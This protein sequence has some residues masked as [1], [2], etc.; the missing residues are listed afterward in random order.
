M[1]LEKYVDKNIKR[2]KII[3]ITISA[4]VL[5]GF[6]FLLYKTFASFTESVEFPMMNGKVDYFGNSDIY[7]VFY[8]GDKQLEE[9]PQKDN[10]ENLVFD[11][12]TCDNGATI[13]W[14]SEEWGPIVKN[15][16]KSKTKCSLYFDEPKP[17]AAEYIKNLAKTD[18]T[19]LAY[20]GIEL[21]GEDIGTND[22]NLRYIGKNPN[23]YIDIGDKD[24]N[25]NPILWRIIGIMN[26]IENYNGNKD[27][28]LKVIR[29]DSIGKYTWD[30]SVNNVND[31]EGVN[32][33]SQAD[34]MKLLNPDFEK[35]QDIDSS[36]ATQTINNSLYWNS[37]KGKCYFYNNNEVSNE[38]VDCDFRS[39]G[40]SNIVKERLEKVYWNTGT[41]ET[42]DDSYI[43]LNTYNA[44]RSSHNGR[45]QCNFLEPYCNDKIDRTT[46]WLGYIGLMYP[47][48]Y[49][50]AVG[51]EAR[52][53]C[54]Q[55][56]LGYFGDFEC[57]NNDWLYNEEYQWTMTP[58]PHS[59]YAQQ[60]YAIFDEGNGLNIGSI[61]SYDIRPVVYLKSSVRI[62]TNPNPEQEYGSIGNPFI[63]E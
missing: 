36:G 40:I 39:S 8:E 45:E 7:F 56:P 21:L 37:E 28:Y 58:A 15:L 41:F 5:V 46:K 4:I 30:T 34:V 29:S 52:N 63:L 38:F 11:H 61:L 27:S 12:G 3:L 42:E 51:E 16:S 23:N 54:L 57:Q 60:V 1:K 25:G 2:R 14:D 18:T 13:E 26:N 53:D 62:A 33:W 47:S 43:Y 22:N 48:D 50:F 59:E 31:G 32:E 19:H 24:G 49:W 10:K 35:N 20:D 17:T 44:E 55:V 9:M 6:S